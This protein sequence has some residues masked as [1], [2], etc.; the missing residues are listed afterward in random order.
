[1]MKTILNRKEL[2]IL[3]EIISNLGYIAR[4]E[5]INALLAKDYSLQEIRKQISLLAQRGWLVRIKRGVFAVADLESHNFANISPLVISRLLLPDSCVSFEFALGQHG[6]F[7]QFPSRL[8]AVTPGKPRKFTFQGLEY[9]Y[10]KIKRDLYFGFEEKT[11]NGGMANIAELEKVILDYL[12][13]RTD[14]YSIDLV[15]EK[16]EEGKGDLD[17]DRLYA[18]VLKFPVSV[19]RRLGFLLDLVGIPTEDLHA[20]LGSRRDFS[21]LT[22]TSD[23]FNARWRIYYED[24]FD[25]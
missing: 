1:M 18:Y 22:G 5:D 15:M 2:A 8:T 10:K 9:V 16:L 4:I 25:K 24:R 17:P 3:E 21:K 12:Y 14:T 20:V 19:R 23:K 7:D 13:Y 11:I 6:L